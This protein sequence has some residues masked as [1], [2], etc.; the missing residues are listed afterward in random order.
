MYYMIEQYQLSSK[1]NCFASYSRTRPAP[2]SI[3]GGNQATYVAKH[4]NAPFDI[5]KDRKYDFAASCSGG[6]RF[7]Q[8]TG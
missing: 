8:F 1:V 5:E 2:L 3:S 4:K 7:Q 6:R